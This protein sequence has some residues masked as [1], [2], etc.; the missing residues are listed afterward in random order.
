MAAAPAA[1]G[2]VVVVPSRR[3]RR[4]AVGWSVSSSSCRAVPSSSSCRRPWGLRDH[5]PPGTSVGAS[6]RRHLQTSQD[7]T[8]RWGELPTDEAVG[9]GTSSPPDQALSRGSPGTTSSSK[10]GD[11]KFPLGIPLNERRESTPATTRRLGNALRERHQ[12]PSMSAGSQ[13]A[14]TSS[15]L[16]KPPGRPPSMSA[17]S[18]PGY[19]P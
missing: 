12:P 10:R 13:P 18:Q 3:R 7:V 4:V 17:G 8:S 9:A 14:T 5:P 16:D 1:A 11:L 15:F 19:D 2:A 6:G